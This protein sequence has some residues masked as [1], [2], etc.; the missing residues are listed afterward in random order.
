MLERKYTPEA[1]HG[2]SLT[3]AVQIC[4]HPE[5]AVIVGGSE[6]KRNPIDMIAAIIEDTLTSGLDYTSTLPDKL[7]RCLIC[8]KPKGQPPDRCP[9]HYDTH[10]G[11]SRVGTT[12]Q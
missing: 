10:A 4:S 12:R 11:R 6:D 5:I 7:W 9:G 1:L 2:L 3:A 8:H